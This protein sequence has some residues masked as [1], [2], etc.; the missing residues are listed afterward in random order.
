M[1]E[2]T[3]FP[4][5]DLT[6][7]LGPMFSGKSTALLRSLGTYADLGF[8]CLYVN[9]KIDSRASATGEIVSNHS[10]AY[11]S[12]SS[13]VDVIAVDSLAEVD[14]KDVKVI[15]VDEA[16]FFDDLLLVVDWVE[17]EDKIVEVAGLDGSFERQPM[18][19][20]LELIPFADTVNKLKAA[21]KECLQQNRLKN[22]PFTA[23]TVQNK[24]PVLVGG[25]EYYTPLCRKCY[26]RLRS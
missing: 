25:F 21:C 15:G 13:K 6:I 7:H 17:C 5:S 16:Q 9:S 18:G 2:G 3:M 24:N 8:S 12:V 23:R 20:V 19:K 11:S 26:L 10:R 1:L 22:A 14:I 4:S